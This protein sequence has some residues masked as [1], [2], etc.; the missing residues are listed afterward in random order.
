MGYRVPTRPEFIEDYVVSTCRFHSEQ[1]SV[2]VVW[3]VTKKDLQGA[4]GVSGWLV[5]LGVILLTLTV[6]QKNEA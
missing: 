1:C 4:F 5:T 6:I 2:W 3:T